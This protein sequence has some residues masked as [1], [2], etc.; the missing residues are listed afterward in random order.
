[1]QR[2]GVRARTAKLVAEAMMVAS[3]GEESCDGELYRLH[4]IQSRWTILVRTAGSDCMAAYL[5][6]LSP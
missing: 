6:K 3:A 4:R 5:S 2:T 1:M